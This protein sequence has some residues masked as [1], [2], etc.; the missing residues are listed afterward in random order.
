MYVLK[1]PVLLLTMYF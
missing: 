1:T